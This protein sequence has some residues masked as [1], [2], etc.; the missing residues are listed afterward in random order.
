M[1]LSILIDLFTK[2]QILNISTIFLFG[3][4]IID[5]GLTD[6]IFVLIEHSIGSV[7]IS[8]L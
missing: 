2:Y 7:N 8:L 5:A 3:K 6:Y 4:S 1:I